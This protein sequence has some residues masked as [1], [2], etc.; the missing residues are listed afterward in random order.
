MILYY[1]GLCSNFTTGKHIR[2]VCFYFT[3]SNLGCPDSA[4]NGYD[5]I[6]DP[7]T[8]LTSKEELVKVN[9]K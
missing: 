1:S 2:N 7:I 8:G 3:D 9:F 5:L 6:T 4:K